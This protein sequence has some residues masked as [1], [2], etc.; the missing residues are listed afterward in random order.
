MSISI[1]IVPLRSLSLLRGTHENDT[2]VLKKSYLSFTDL[3]LK[4]PEPKE[5]H[6]WGPKSGRRSAAVQWQLSK[7][8]KVR[9]DEGNNRSERQKKRGTV[10]KQQPCVSPFLSFSAELRKSSKWYVPRG[11]HTLFLFFV[12]AMSLSLDRGASCHLSS[13]QRKH[14]FATVGLCAFWLETGFKPKFLYLLDPSNV[15]LRSMIDLRGTFL[16]VGIG[17]LQIGNTL[18]DLAWPRKYLLDRWSI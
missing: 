7:A 16:G 11:Q 2:C 18:F 14:I 10:R 15:P 6:G 17:Y 8:S 3:I 1:T 13:I 4:G 9:E 5:A 12:V